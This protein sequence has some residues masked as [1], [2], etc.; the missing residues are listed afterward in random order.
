MIMARRV[1]CR[2]V[3]LS[4]ATVE[5]QYPLY[6]ATVLCSSVQTCMTWVFM[7]NTGVGLLLGA[8]ASEYAQ[9]VGGP[10]IARIIV[11]TYR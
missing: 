8:T 7:I 3:V 2:H 6:A 4:E 9:H 5:Q 10:F 11:E 1:C